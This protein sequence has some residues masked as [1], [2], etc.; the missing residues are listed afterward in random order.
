MRR[1]EHKVVIVTGGTGGLGR[2]VCDRLEQLGA[3]V[4]ACGRKMPENA[5][6]KRMAKID[7]K[8]ISELQRWISGIIAGEGRVDILVNAAGVCPLADWQEVTEELW[9]DVMAVNLKSVFFASKAV[10]GAM[11][12]QGKGAIINIGSTSAYNG[13]IVTAPPYGA[14][15]GGVHTLTKW[16]AAKT[17]ANGIRVNTIAPGP[18]NSAMTDAFSSEMRL[19]LESRTPNGRLGTQED[20]AE[21]VLFLADEATAGHITG[22]ALD[23]CGGAYMR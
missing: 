12:A 5:A 1:F 16:L 11:I 4:Y 2:T 23:I 14:S 6:D 17:A 15:K 3:T 20:V 7:V 8:N 9:D 18:F 22:A 19:N 10:L 21:A 13:G